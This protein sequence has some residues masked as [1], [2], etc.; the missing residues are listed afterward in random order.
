[1]SCCEVSVAKPHLIWQV[2]DIDA[3]SSWAVHHVGPACNHTKGNKV[4][5]KQDT[6]VS[7]DLRLCYHA[8]RARSGHPR[9]PNSR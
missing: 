2:L 4:R 5:S 8:R 9:D 7:L 6:A 1:M 3:A